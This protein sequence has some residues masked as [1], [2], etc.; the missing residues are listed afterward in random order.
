MFQGRCLSD[1]RDWSLLSSIWGKRD[2]DDEVSVVINSRMIEE[3]IW[4]AIQSQESLD[5]VGKKQGDTVIG[6]IEAANVVID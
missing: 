3:D 6:G 2:D 4:Q 5:E 1:T